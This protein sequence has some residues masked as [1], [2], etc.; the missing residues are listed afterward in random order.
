MSWRELVT[1]FPCKLHDQ[2]KWKRN[3]SVRG[4]EPT[5]SCSPASQ[6]LTCFA[7]QDTYGMPAPDCLCHDP[8][9]H[10]FT[11]TT[12]T[13][14]LC[15][16]PGPALSPS[17]SHPP[18]CQDGQLRGCTGPRWDCWAGA[19]RTHTY[20]AVSAGCKQASLGTLFHFLI[21][22]SSAGSWLPQLEIL[23]LTVCN[24]QL[25][26]C[27]GQ[28]REAGDPARCWALVGWTRPLAQPNINSWSRSMLFTD[29]SWLLC[30]PGRCM[31]SPHF[32]MDRRYISSKDMPGPGPGLGLPGSSHH[33]A[34][35]PHGELSPRPSNAPCGSGAELMSFPPPHPCGRAT[36]QE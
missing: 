33:F 17:L 32:N 16:R 18:V 15:P 7:G 14:S 31:P 1:F 2:H 9:P 12:V 5:V 3:K 10:S 13:S 21:F 27:D 6:G 28:H 23:G 30:L 35:H 26:S 24:T 25:S 34:S 29:T 4:I 20:S 22:T 19:V 11:Y 36:A 8:P